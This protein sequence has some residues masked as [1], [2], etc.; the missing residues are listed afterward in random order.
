M[1][2]QN[3]LNE[4]EKKLDAAKSVVAN[5]KQ[6]K[7]DLWDLY[8]LIEE[9]YGAASDVTKFMRRNEDCELAAHECLVLDG[10]GG[11]YSKLRAALEKWNAMVLKFMTIKELYPLIYTDLKPAEDEIEKNAM[12][13][14]Y[15][16][17]ILIKNSNLGKRKKN[18]TIFVGTG[19]GQRSA[20]RKTIF[21]NRRHPTPIMAAPGSGE[22]T[23]YR[24]TLEAMHLRS[25]Y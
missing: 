18:L 23:L 20:S 16:S 12:E 3:A 7:T 6:I 11:G 17:L 9:F 1:G 10:P 22:P 14:I 19:C 4:A 24:W 5:R 2:A 8:D 21:T 25:S 13:E 15:L